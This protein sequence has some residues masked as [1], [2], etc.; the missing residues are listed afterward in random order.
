MKKLALIL[1]LTLPYGL[2]AGEQLSE[3]AK[4]ASNDLWLSD[5][6]SDAFISFSTSFQSGLARR[7]VETGAYDLSVRAKGLKILFGSPTCNHCM[8]DGFFSAVDIEGYVGDGPMWVGLRNLGG[9]FALHKHYERLQHTNDELHNAHRP[10]FMVKQPITAIILTPSYLLGA[11]FA[12]RFGG[13]DISI[14]CEPVGLFLANGSAPTTHVRLFTESYGYT[15]A[16]K[17]NAMSARLFFGGY[18]EHAFSGENREWSVKFS[19][20]SMV[21]GVAGLQGALGFLRFGSAYGYQ[22]HSGSTS[23]VLDNSYAYFYRSRSGSAWQEAPRNESQPAEVS[24]V[25]MTSA[26]ALTSVAAGGAHKLTSYVA[27]TFDRFTVGLSCQNALHSVGHS[28]IEYMRL[29]FG[30]SV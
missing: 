10:L 2:V 11:T 5:K 16:L 13:I 3:P 15:A 27:A 22:W 25:G 9:G 6:A 7:F 28:P 1:I 17:H 14:G 24:D 21:G 19:P 29:V 30:F 26:P 4:K 20:G 8:P 18:A 12:G 23:A